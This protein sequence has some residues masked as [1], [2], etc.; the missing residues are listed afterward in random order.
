MRFR[1]ICETS[2]CETSLCE[3]SLCET[4]LCDVKKIKKFRRNFLF[5]SYNLFFVAL[6]NSSY[7]SSRYH[8]H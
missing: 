3:T 2:L 6:N 5:F 1:V 8:A 7:A 4:S